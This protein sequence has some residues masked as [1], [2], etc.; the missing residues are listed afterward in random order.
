MDINLK[1]L[2]LPAEL[3]GQALKHSS[4]LQ[5][6]KT[7]KYLRDFTKKHTLT[8]GFDHQKTWVMFFL[9]YGL[10]LLGEKGM[11]FSEFSELEQLSICDY[12][13]KFWNEEDGKKPTL[14]LIN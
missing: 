3:K 6:A 11:T 4:R 5:R 14:V 13:S 10:E 2:D 12:Y 1:E 7:A 8:Q 9:L